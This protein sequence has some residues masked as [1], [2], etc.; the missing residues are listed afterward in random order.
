MNEIKLVR[1]LKKLNQIKPEKQFVLSTKKQILGE[2]PRFG[3][4]VNLKPVYAGVFC[5]FLLL[6][7]FQ[8]QNALPGESLFYLKKI[9]ER[10]QIMFSSEDQKPGLSLLL[11][12][13]RLADLSFLAEKN[14][15]QRLA[16]A[17]DE[18]KANVNEVVKNLAKVTEINEKFVAQIRELEETKQEVER[19]LATK[20]ETQE[21]DDAL[22]D[23]VQQ[24]IEYLGQRT[25]NEED[26]EILEQIKE[27]F[28]KQEYSE[29]LIR[30]LD[31]NHN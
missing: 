13:R 28:E 31:L 8:V 9:A 15:A 2:D 23:L 21:F 3:L 27:L 4:F 26:L 10:G 16:P 30:I 6:A 7:I 20:I 22:A 11:A 5:L 18:F 17:I 19:V 1:E 25:L 24:Q 29:S 14:K 12:N